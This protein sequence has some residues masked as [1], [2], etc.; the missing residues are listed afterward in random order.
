VLSGVHE[1][2]GNKYC[3]R[4]DAGKYVRADKRRNGEIIVI[5][6]AIRFLEGGL[7]GLSWT[8]IFAGDVSF[9]SGFH[10]VQKVAR[11]GIIMSG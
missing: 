9:I 11:H 3:S 8:L 4:L 7:T 10:R 6:K 5:S 2:V 1:Q